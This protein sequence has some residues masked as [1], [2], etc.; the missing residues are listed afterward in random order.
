MQPQIQSPTPILFAVS[1]PLDPPPIVPPLAWLQA[2]RDEWRDRKDVLERELVQAI[3]DH[4]AASAN[5]E[6]IERLLSL[7]E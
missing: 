1:A 4:A 2:E 7:Y 6:A 5:L 3:E